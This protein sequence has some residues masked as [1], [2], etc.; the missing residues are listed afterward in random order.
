[1]NLSAYRSCRKD[2]RLRGALGQSLCL[3]LLTAAYCVGIAFS[4]AEYDP[5]LDLLVGLSAANYL[6]MRR[7]S[8]A[9]GVSNGLGV[10]NAMRVSKALGVNP[11]PA[12]P[13]VAIPS[14]ARS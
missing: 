3:I 12:A 1:M 7:E 5:H 14:P 2:K 9:L 13:P 8:Q 10:N 11:S 4:N 6:A